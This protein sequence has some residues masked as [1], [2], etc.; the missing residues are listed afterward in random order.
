MKTG[1]LKQRLNNEIQKRRESNAWNF[2][3]AARVIETKKKSKKRALYLTSVSSFSFAALAVL[4]L[5]FGITQPQENIYEQFVTRQVKGTYELVTDKNY[6]M[7]SSENIE[8]TTDLIFTGEIDSIID[9]T[10]SMR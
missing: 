8:S 7:T 2:E 4:F 3:I 1:E 9:N 10:L 5:M 6:K